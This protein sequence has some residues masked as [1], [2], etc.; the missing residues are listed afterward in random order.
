[1]VASNIERGKHMKWIVIVGNVVDGLTFFGPFYNREAALDWT[2][3]NPIDSDWTIGP[4]AEPS[5]YPEL[6]DYDAIG[7]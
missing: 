2:E 3:A 6:Q 1:V 5:A 4:L 7:V